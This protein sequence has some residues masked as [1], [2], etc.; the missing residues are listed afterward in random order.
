MSEHVTFCRICEPFCGLVA[1]VEDGQLTRLRPD[2]ANPVSKGFACPKGIAMTEIQNDPDRV[3]HPLR[4]RADGEFERVSWDEA[5]SDITA[6]LRR[7]KDAHGTESIGWYMGNPAGASYAH[8]IWATGFLKALDTRHFY[9]VGSQDQNS[10][11]VASALLYG[12]PLL[13]PIPDLARTDFLLIAGANPYVSHGSGISAPRIR[14]AIAGITQRGGRVVVVDPRR[15]QTAQANEWVPI[16]P[17]TDALMLLAMLQVLFEEGLTDDRAVGDVADGLEGLRALSAGFPPESTADATGVPAE[18]VRQLARDLAAARS[19]VVYGRVG[20]CVGSFGSLVCFLLDAL[21]VVTGNLDRPGG[22]IFADPP[23]G[24][25][26]FVRRFGLASYATQRSRLGGLPDVLGQ[27]PATLMAKEITTPGRGQLRALLVSAGNP[28]LSCPD[29][30]ELEAALPELD[31]MV[32]LD[33]YVNETNRHADYVLPAATFLEREDVPIFT[34]SEQLQPFIQTTK[35][36]VPPRGEAREDWKIIDEIAWGIGVPPY[37]VAPARALARLGV[38]PTPRQMVDLLIRTGPKG[39]WFGLRRGGLSLKMLEQHPHGLTLGDHNETGILA[40]KVA[41]RSRKVRLDPPEIAAE[42]RRLSAATEAR[43]PERRFRLIGMRELRS[44]N[45]WMHNSPKLMRGDRTVRARIHPDDAQEIGVGDGD[46][47]RISSKTGAIELPARVTA[48]ITPGT[49]AIPHGW[50]HRGGWRIANAA[51]A[52]NI[53][54]LASAELGD[55]E[56]LAGMSR[57]SGI[58]IAVER[59]GGPYEPATAP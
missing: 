17:D 4:R 28:V 40:K 27:M 54:R 42:V 32:S 37:A 30:D 23:I 9:S 24:I 12:S 15:T 35:A 57:L 48:D 43:D 58:P 29:G 18:T 19:A 56:Q 25:E 45:S 33:L 20:T 14:D 10:R 22:S 31:L 44:H 50:G 49:V 5:M 53:N 26:G 41:H 7:I 47:V 36:V 11:L 13:I 51:E 8:L 46:R 55:L 38:R 21:N 6:R 3:V 59:V 2:D 34:L 1:T 16:T 39:D 52:P